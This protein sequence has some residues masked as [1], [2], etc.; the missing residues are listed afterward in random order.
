M[1]MVF[2]FTITTAAVGMM[3]QIMWYAWLLLVMECVQRWTDDI[4]IVQR[5]PMAMRVLL[6]SYMCYALMVAGAFGGAPYLY[7]QF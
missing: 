4:M 6:Y 1:N 2:N 7:F 5:W 3:I